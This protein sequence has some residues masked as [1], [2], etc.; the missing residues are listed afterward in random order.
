[1]KQQFHNLCLMYRDGIVHKGDTERLNDVLKEIVM[2]VMNITFGNYK[3]IQLC[4]VFEY[5]KNILKSSSKHHKQSVIKVIDR[6]T[7]D[8]L[9]QTEEGFYKR[10]PEFTP[11]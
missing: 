1:M 9:L 3:G 4:Q 7:N 2:I 11:I 8:F 10:W 6:V 5:L